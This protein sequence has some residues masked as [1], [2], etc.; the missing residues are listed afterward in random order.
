MTSGVNPDGEGFVTIAAHGTE[1]TVL[2]GQLNPDDIRQHA[3]GYLETAEAAEQ[4]AAVLRLI[5]NLGLP[6]E[7]A[8][9]V[10]TE[11]RKSRN[12]A[13]DEEDGQPDD[14]N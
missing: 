14:G 2:I 12:D 13:Y 3:L 7:I 9:L 1:G 5:R 8:G 4:D 11:L 6:D 10:I